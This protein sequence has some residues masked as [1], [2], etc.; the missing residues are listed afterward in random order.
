[1]GFLILTTPIMLNFN[2]LSFE[3]LIVHHIAAKQPHEDAASPHYENDLFQITDKV[4]TKIKERLI[5]AAGKNSKAFELEL[6]STETGSFFDLAKD[7][8]SYSKKVFIQ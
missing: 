5:D 1:M 2:N 3:R 8:R 4:E 6:E 7:L